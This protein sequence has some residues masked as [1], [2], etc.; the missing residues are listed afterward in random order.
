MSPTP[1]AKRWR[2]PVFLAISAAVAVTVILLAHAVLLPFVMALVIAYVLAPAVTW[3]EH[4]RV[5]RGLAI[6]LV[7][8]VMLGSIAL[9]VRMIAPRIGH[10]VQNLH[11]ELP[12]LGKEAKEKWVPAIAEKLRS[13]GIAEP[14]EDKDE[15]EEPPAG[16]LVARTLPDGGGIAIDIGTGFSINETHKGYSVEPT[17]ERRDRFDPNRLLSDAVGQTFSYARENS[18][19]IARIGRN[20]LAAVSRTIFVFF[21]TLML[22]A[23]LMMTRERIFAFFFSLI[24]PSSRP[25][26]ESLLA[27]IDRGLSGV[28]RGQLIICLINGVLSAIGFAIVGLKYW[29]VLALIAAV[30]SLIP[31]FG[32]IFSSV[33]AVAVGL[34]QG[35]GTAA[36]V[37]V[38]IIGIHQVEANVLNPKIMGDAAKIHPVLVVFAL[39]VGE[40]FFQA[41]GSLLAVPCMSIALSVFMHFRAIV[42]KSDP[43]LA[44]EPVDSMATAPVEARGPG[45]PDA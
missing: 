32:A 25:A 19:E 34:T 3:V 14:E 9:F 31:I 37:L 40:H 20:I 22:A 24:R 35:V 44:E 11:H 27:R 36:F 1:P 7:Y 16:A 30:L 26:F 42:Q 6:I 21:I 39:L 2:R 5:P 4:R 43:E 33:P 10:E 29:P 15:R 23:Y 18:L 12:Q 17:R 13:I 41:V 38:W 28:V 8:A 45:T